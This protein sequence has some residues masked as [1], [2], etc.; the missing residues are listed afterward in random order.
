MRVACA[1][2]EGGEGGCAYA[3]DNWA[4]CVSKKKSAMNKA[5]NP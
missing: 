3:V 4:M 2:F 5:Y 1:S